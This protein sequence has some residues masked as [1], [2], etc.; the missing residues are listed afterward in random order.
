MK[1]RYIISLFMLS[2]SLFSA[3]TSLSEVSPYRGDWKGPTRHRS[4][5]EAPPSHLTPDSR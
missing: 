1:K 4:H 3:C 5:K 2:I